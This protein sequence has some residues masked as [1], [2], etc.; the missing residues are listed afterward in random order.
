MEQLRLKQHRIEGIAFAKARWI[1][2]PITPVLGIC[3]DTASRLEPLSAARYLQDNTAKSKPSVHFVVERDG[4]VQQQVPT[5]RGANHA[6]SSSYHG[7]PGCN[8][9]SIGMEIVNP[10][11]MTF[12]GNNKVRAW[13]GELFDID[14]CEIVQIDT[15]QHGAGRWW[16]PYPQAQLATVGLIWEALFA[17]I[18]TLM[19]LRTH[20]YVSPG[21]K[22]DT[23]PL[24]PL[25]QLRA[26]LLGREEPSDVEA[27]ALATEVAG[28]A[29]LRID[30]PG[31]TLNLRRWPS[32][33]PNVLAAIPHGA[34]VPL[35]KTGT[36]AGRTWHKVLYAGQ[37]GWIVG[38][39][40][41]AV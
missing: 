35:L 18:P 13:W 37:E 22:V 38:R 39:Y 12:A 5:N 20:W 10:G 14:A 6:G 8:G 15:P 2:G 40:A 1:N 21:R 31:D 36:F 16:M 17:S 3:H 7:R 32:F 11:F 30:L 41:V 27:D 25:E 34:I 19:D 4:A 24:F 29:Y 33:N 23:N 26:K 28:D 9:F